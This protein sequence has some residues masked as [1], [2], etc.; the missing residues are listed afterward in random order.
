MCHVRVLCVLVHR[1]MELLMLIFTSTAHFQHVFLI[2]VRAYVRIKV[3]MHVHILYNDMRIRVRWYLQTV[4]C[5]YV[6]IF[7]H[8]YICVHIRVNVHV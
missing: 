6:H 2:N 3:C 8:I 1:R 7:V 5:T 4:T